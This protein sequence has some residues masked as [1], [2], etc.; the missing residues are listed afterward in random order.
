VGDHEVAVLGVISGGDDAVGSSAAPQLSPGVEIDGLVGDLRLDGAADT[1]TGGGGDDCLTGDHA[2]RVA[3][4]IAGP[5]PADGAR[6]EIESLAGDVRL[7]GGG[8]RLDGA[9]GDDTLIGD[10]RV[11][12]TGLVV[13]ADGALGD[14]EF[15]VDGAICAL[16]LEGGKD[17][18]LGGA[19]ADALYGDHAVSFTGVA[20]PAAEPGGGLAGASTRPPLLEVERLVGSVDIRGNRDALDG[21]E[22]DDA[23]YGDHAVS[24]AGVAGA[25]GEGRS[26][27][28]EIEE[29][30]L[31]CVEIRG[32]DDAVRGGGG[33]DRAFGDSRI[34]VAGMAG[35]VAA[36]G[37]LEVEIGG[38]VDR[39]DVEAGDDELRGEAGDDALAGDNELLVA[40]L[41]LEGGV[42]GALVVEADGLVGALEL[43]AGCD[44][45]DGGDGADALVGDQVLAIAAVLDSTGAPAAADGA[46]ELDIHELVRCLEAEARGDA[47]DGGAGDDLL[48]GDTRAVVAAYLGSFAAPIAANLAITGDRLVRDFDIEAGGDSLRGR[49]G[50]DVLVGDGDTTV[51]LAAG[52]AAVPAGAFDMDAL[53][54][55]LG[56]AAR[57][58]SLKGDAGGNLI[59]QGNRAVAP[60]ELVEKRS[61]SSWS[62]TNAPAAPPAIDWSGA[63]CGAALEGLWGRAHGGA[64]WITGFVNELG[65]SPDEQNPNR[66][67]RVFV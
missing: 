36:G 14:R 11:A 39:L 26:L 60:R 9:A 37:L 58:D 63:A 38:L 62:K 43:G 42:A 15:E 17:A 34:E 64:G 30:L 23:L 44:A 4:V 59:E 65:R 6:V 45:L 22:G 46:I 54:R 12:I 18:L 51:A 52:A 2:L 67:I 1:L 27:R 31:G 3:G 29:R 20:L 13:L 40:G 47:L 10:H 32:A 19:G 21:G 33:D 57:G 55:N 61:I 5:Q 25:A 56:V 50:A 49:D 66:R 24:I 35:A 53:V 41:V 48:I 7:Y 8:D 16:R 28:V